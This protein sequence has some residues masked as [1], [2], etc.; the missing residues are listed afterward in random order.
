MTVELEPRLDAIQL[1]VM[2]NRLISVVNEQAAALMRTSFTSIVREAGDLSAGV[3]DVGGNMIAQ[4]VTGTPGHINAMATCIH[5][6][7]AVYPAATLRPGDVLI[8]NDPQ[9]T[10]GHLHD[11][12]VITPVFRG[13]TLVGY[14][15]NT[16]HVLD[17]GG[18]GLSTDARSVFEEGLFVPITK[19]FD[20]GEPNRELLKILSANVRAPEP[21]LGDIHAQAA[22]NDV[23][24]ARLLEF[25]EEFRLDSL[26]ELS[27]E[28]IGRSERAMRAAIAALPDGVYENEVFSDGYEEPVRLHV[29]ITKRGDEMLVDWAGSSP[30]SRRGINV[31]LNYTH[32][33]TTYALKCALAPE[34]PN[35]EGSFRP[36]KVTAPPRSIL[37][38]L[39]PAAVAARHIL[40]HFLPGAVFGALAKAVPDRV[41]AEGAANIWNLQFTGHDLDDRPFTYVWFS[42][43]GTGA[44]PTKDGLH[45]TAFPSGIAGVPAEVIEQLSPVIVHAR[46]IRADSAGPG[47]FRGG[48]GQTLRLGVRTNRPY[49]F[50]PLFDRLHHPAAGYAGG[51]PG[52]T[53]DISLSTGEHY[54]GKGSREL[55]PATMIT[56]Q[57][58]GGGGFFDPFT[59]DP[60]AVLADVESGLVSPEHAHTEYGVVL[61]AAGGID[62]EATAAI[63]G[64]SGVD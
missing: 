21:V 45:A 15:G 16:C 9:K 63:R 3:F 2:W 24:A 44:R 58:P 27:A 40:G 33:Y 35:N 20:A 36:V 26:D 37:N 11:F 64:P 1:E 60:A 23:G 7:L 34:V 29:A 47:Q 19:L 57:L 5:H 12:T 17:I 48:C 30:E 13:E 32:A 10:S 42:C 49:T 14:L 51:K 4:A 61:N 39:P 25:M 31:V 46:E 50:S 41:I 62:L 38:A 59:R 18:I 43:G 53:A 28:I 6:F 8:T 56:L 22:G 55:A 52:A 54:A